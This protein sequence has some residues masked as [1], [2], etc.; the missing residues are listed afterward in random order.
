MKSYTIPSGIIPVTNAAGTLL[1]AGRYDGI[2]QLFH[3]AGADIT[4]VDMSNI[5]GVDDDLTLDRLAE[6]ALMLSLD[7]EIVAGRLDAFM[8]GNSLFAFQ[9]GNGEL[10]IFIPGANG[11]LKCM[12]PESGLEVQLPPLSTRGTALV[13][14][15]M[16]DE[17]APPANGLSAWLRLARE[18]TNNVFSYLVGL[19]ALSNL[20]GLALPLFTLAVYDQVLAAENR[21]ILSM[22]VLGL[23]L[24]VGG[25]LLLR[26]LRSAS[27]S[28]L[29]AQVDMR[30]SSLLFASMI[31]G[32]NVVP[33]GIS[34]R[35][36]LSRMRDMDLLREYFV[37]ATGVALLEAP[38]FALY[39]LVLF[40]IGGW[41][42]MVPAVTLLVGVFL[43][44]ASLGSAVRRNKSDVHQSQ[45]YGATCNEIAGRYDAIKREGYL[46]N[47]ADRFRAA[48]AR[49]SEADIS[50]QR[51]M[52]SAQLASTT[53]V[54]F[55]V[56]STLGAGTVLVI[57][58]ALSVG[59]LIAS[60]AL[61]WRMTAQ[62]PSLIIARLRWPEVQDALNASNAVLNADLGVKSDNG[63][64]GRGRGMSGNVS[65]SSVMLTHQRGFVP[66]IRNLSVD[67]KP[68]EIVAITG[69]SGAGKSSMLD[70][71]A[72]VVEPQFGTVTIDGINPRQISSS[73]FRQSLGYLPREHGTL[74]V[75]IREF[76]TLGVELGLRQNCHEICLRTG[77][78][79]LI[80]RLPK[81]L[82]TRMSDLDASGGLVRGIALARVLATDS[83]LYLFDDPDSS[84]ASARRALLS[85]IERIRGNATI[86]IATHEPEFIAAADRVLV[87]NQGSLVR[88][89][90]PGELAQAKRVVNQ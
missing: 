58:G 83:S 4:P 84:S 16:I 2:R 67:I 45:E 25:D 7:P 44:L 79:P 75:S 62:L 28:R 53:L 38:F 51:I 64:G 87:L 11:T 90:A 50:R 69:H 17:V 24:A 21:S 1:T 61:V 39:L 40:L 85:E 77:I 81:G 55:T 42:V 65:F 78:M 71:I 36:G 74:P 41:L 6:V 20:L 46:A 12:A 22:L 43:I 86:I 8:L 70:L 32:A 33:G 9:C 80:E 31:R 29:A 34:A 48:S 18:S 88:D 15:M 10:C 26:T 23:A 27:L 52:I 57:N 49:M 66:A 73:A 5:V 3:L 60:V 19:T 47:W 14:T 54:S 13:L 72:G 76:L 37:G 35:A 59:A 68:N 63:L 89:C 82:D 56:I 30:T